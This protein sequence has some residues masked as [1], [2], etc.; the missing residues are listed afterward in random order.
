MPF[1]VIHIVASLNPT[2]GGPSQSVL[3]LACAQAEAGARVALASLDYHPASRPTGDLTLKI[4]PGNFPRLIACSREL[5]HFLQSTPATVVHHHGLWLRTL[6]YAHAAARRH[7][8]ALVISPRG[9]LEPW[10]RQHHGLRK[11]FA[12]HFIHPGAIEAASGWHAT[13]AA[14]ATNFVDA[15][16]SRPVCIAPNGIHA[17]T[18][19]WLEQARQAWYAIAPELAGK[20]VALFYGRFHPKKRLR[21]LIQIWASK[22]RP[23]WTLLI[24]GIPEY[25]SVDTL[26]NYAAKIGA[27]KSVRVETGINRPHPYAIASLFV[28][29]SH[30]ENFGQTVVES[31]AARVPALVTDSTPW[32]MLNQKDAGWCVPWSKYPATL[33][34]ALSLSPEALNEIGDRGRTYAIDHYNWSAV[35]KR[36]LDFYQTLSPCGAQRVQPG[37]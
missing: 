28:L 36:V 24:A 12:R 30:S 1:N 6:H 21:E 10:A 19:K 16:A 2:Q 15:S 34:Q 20:Q 22:A 29:P 18:D 17:P 35:A 27:A 11:K 33:D 25:Y 8:A 32:S 13:S 3:A 14:E 31:L 7:K 23:G 37:A 5:R 9:M 4:V 26:R